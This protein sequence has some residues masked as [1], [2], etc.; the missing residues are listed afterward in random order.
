[1]VN[2]IL[3]GIPGV[4]GGRAG[5]FCMATGD[6]FSGKRGAYLGCQSESHHPD[7]LLVNNGLNERVDHYAAAATSIT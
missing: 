4:E 5:S 7:K 2:V 3:F 6:G 1:L